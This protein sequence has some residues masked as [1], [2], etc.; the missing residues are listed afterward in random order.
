MW[1]LTR[2]SVCSCPHVA[3]SF[4]ITE[5]PDV[6][7]AMMATVLTLEAKF[8]IKLR[9]CLLNEKRAASGDQCETCETGYFMDGERCRLCTDGMSCTTAGLTV[10]TLPLEDDWWRTS[11]ESDQV[12]RCYSEGACVSGACR[13]GHKGPLCAVCEEK[14]FLNPAG[15][16]KRCSNS[17]PDW[18]YALA[19]AIFGCVVASVCSF[20]WTG[21]VMSWRSVIGIKKSRSLQRRLSTREFSL[22]ADQ[23]AVESRRRF[24]R[25][26]SV[27]KLL[28]N[29][30]VRL[31]G[32]ASARA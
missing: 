13:D 28:I 31:L 30:N 4:S 8:V 20:I 16:C 24:Q 26:V 23:L 32:C 29:F 3:G 15:L 18:T 22:R 9:P 17:S 12:R 19:V 5:S 11:L 14:W 25:Y 2:K 6:E 1:F 7:V 10:S 21:A 27:L